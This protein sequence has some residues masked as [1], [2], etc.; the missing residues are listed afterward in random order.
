MPCSERNQF[1]AR[2]TKRNGAGIIRAKGTNRHRVSAG[3]VL[4]MLARLRYVLAAS[5]SSPPASL[6][7]QALLRLRIASQ[8]QFPLRFP[9]AET[10]AMEHELLYAPAGEFVE[11]LPGRNHRGA[12][13]ADFVRPVGC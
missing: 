5:P 10:R 9:D 4:A 1:P 2:G 13:V 12:C 3:S 8:D 11:Y 7:V 6:T